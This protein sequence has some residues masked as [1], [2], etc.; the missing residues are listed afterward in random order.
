MGHL[1]L[2]FSLFFCFLSEKRL[3]PFRITTDLFSFSCH[4]WTEPQPIVVR[5]S[6]LPALQDLIFCVAFL[7]LFPNFTIASTIF[8]QKHGVD[9]IKPVVKKNQPNWN[10]T[11][12]LYLGTSMITFLNPI[13]ISSD[14]ILNNYVHAN[15]KKYLTDNY[16]YQ[17]DP[18]KKMSKL[19]DTLPTYYQYISMFVVCYR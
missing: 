15:D 18:T 16:S 13:W 19:F 1:L 5:P 4:D 8:P 14:R 11:I 9:G 10:E 12:H 6:Y 17:I 7:S 3:S 2:C